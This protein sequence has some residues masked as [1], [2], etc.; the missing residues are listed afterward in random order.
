M[1]AKDF[2]PVYDV[3]EL[4]PFSRACPEGQHF[5]TE[6][7][8]TCANTKA[9]EQT[10]MAQVLAICAMVHTKPLLAIGL[11]GLQLFQYFC[12]S[13]LI[14][15]CGQRPALVELKDASSLIANQ[16]IRD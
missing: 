3:Q 2:G 11:G 12:S 9:R 14:T 4:V 10:S 5:F 7:V 16:S 13:M 1:A 6:T 15:E 8:S